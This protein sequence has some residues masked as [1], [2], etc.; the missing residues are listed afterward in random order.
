MLVLLSPSKKLDYEQPVNTNIATQPVF[1]TDTQNLAAQL[2]GLSASEVGGLMH[3][4]D[5]LAKLNYERY[6]SF[7]V[8]FTKENARPALYAFKGDVY[9]NMDIQGYGDDDLLFAQEHV[10]LLSGLYGLLKP[11]DLMQ[12]YRLEMGTS[13]KNDKGKNLYEFWGTKLTDEINNRAD[14]LVVNLA[15][16][17]YFKA[18]KPKNLKGKLLTVQL[19]QY[20]GGK[21][22]TIGLMAKRARGMM[23][24]YIIKNKITSADD[25]MK[26]DAGG[27]KFEPEMSNEDTWV[28]TMHM[29]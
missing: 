4:S 13:F 1:L 10:A 27:Y 28:F 2:K 9:D 15:S 20:K 11:L 29:D 22:K 12:P 18:V 7:S 19:K 24:D 21:L 3:L 23:C 14:G 25:L 8:P 5:N 16:A 6:Q 17:E 26:F